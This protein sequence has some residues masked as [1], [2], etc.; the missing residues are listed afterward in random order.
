MIT[1]A[2]TSASQK[3]PVVA[4][5]EDAHVGAEHEQLAVREVHHVHDAEDEGQPRGN[6]GQDHPGDDA[7]DGLDDDDVPGD[8]HRF[9]LPGIC[10]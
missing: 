9:T 3:L 2:T 8:V 10:E 5:V 6:Q 4:N 7:V 1:I